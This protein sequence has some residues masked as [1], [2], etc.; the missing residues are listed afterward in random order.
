VSAEPGAGQFTSPKA[1]RFQ[2]VFPKACQAVV[3]ALG[4]K[5]FHVR[6]P[7]NTSVLDAT[8][9]AVLE[10]NGSVPDDFKVQY[11]KLNADEDF[12]EKIRVSTTDTVTVRTRIRSAKKYLKL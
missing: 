12:Q 10:A 9:I 11:R 8:M 3:K 7:L 1:K 5:P 4:A 2:T 6:G